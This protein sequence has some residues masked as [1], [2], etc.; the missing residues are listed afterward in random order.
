MRRLALILATAGLAAC[1]G[2]G[3][4]DSSPPSSVA[5]KPGVLAISAFPR[6]NPP[7]ATPQETVARLSESFDLVYNA[8]ARGQ[9]TSF[10]WSALEPTKGA[11][12]AQQFD[13]LN[14]AINSAQS[15]GM[16][17]LVGLQVINTTARELPAELQA[18]AFDDPAVTLQFHALLERVLTPANRGRIA[19]LSIGN[20]VDVYL[21]AHPAEWQRYKLFYEDALQYAHALDPS[22][23]VGVTG[24][25]DGV[26]QSPSELTDLNAQS[27]VMILT[28][29]PLQSIAGATAVRSPSV[30]AGDFALM[31]GLAGAKPLLLQEVGYPAATA[32]L[33]SEAM[34]AQFVS[35]VFAAWKAANGKIPFLNYF[36][37][38]DFTQQMCDDFGVYYGAPSDTSFKAFL[39]SLG[40]RKDDGTPRAAWSTLQSEAAGAGLP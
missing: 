18:L 37:L 11:Y 31:L 16:V 22:V 12:S 36:L 17:E 15:H 21:R 38:H 8:G 10:R 26:M 6:F 32:N 20:E 3:G 27:D 23:K 7:P 19:Y 28:Y 25:I 9:F 34:Q 24:T 4:G 1:G 29:Y 40:L 39:C 33:S 5:R 30:V 35:N 14:A 13:D 2:G